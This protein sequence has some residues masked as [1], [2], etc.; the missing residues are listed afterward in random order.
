VEAFLNGERRQH[1]NTGNM[2]FGV[3]ALVSFISR[4]M[5]LL[6]GDVIATGT[7]AGIG[8]MQ[9]GDV[10]EVKL[11]GIGALRNRLVA[12]SFVKAG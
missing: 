10:V 12:G 3:A 11:E 8:P 4:I 7:P 2:V 9:P 6:P 1:G 5:T